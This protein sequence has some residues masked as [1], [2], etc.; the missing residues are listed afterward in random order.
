MATMRIVLDGVTAQKTGCQG[1]H[2]LQQS[3]PK[4]NA[5]NLRESMAREQGLGA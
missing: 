3:P 2:P 4:K 5:Q 1:C